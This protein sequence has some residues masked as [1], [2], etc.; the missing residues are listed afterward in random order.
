M[1]LA[2][3]A[4]SGIKADIFDRFI[5]EISLNVI[6]IA[7]SSHLVFEMHCALVGKL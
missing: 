1:T 2:E 5:Q 7:S 4:R 3:T 6:K